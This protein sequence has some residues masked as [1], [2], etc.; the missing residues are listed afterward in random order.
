M[1]KRILTFLAAMS[2]QTLPGVARAQ[3]LDEPLCIPVASPS[4]WA[5]RPSVTLGMSF[6]FSDKVLGAFPV[7]SCEADL[8]A[9]MDNQGFDEKQLSYSD[10]AFGD[11]PNEIER[12]LRRLRDGTT[13]SLRRLKTWAP[14][15]HSH[16]SVAWNTDEFGR[17]T[18]VFAD[19][20][21][22]QFDLP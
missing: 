22:F 2:L 12:E 10:V 6:N 19:T 14:I 20:E 8:V 3:A 17:L 5:P 16:Y 21:L 9:W 11:Q 13:I 4:K 7:G 18:E 15:G 1:Y